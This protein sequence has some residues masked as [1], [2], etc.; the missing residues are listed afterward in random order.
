MITPLCN[1]RRCP[2]IAPNPEKVQMQLLCVKNLY[3]LSPFT[4]TPKFQLSKFWAFPTRAC[5]ELGLTID[6]ERLVLW[7]FSSLVVL[8]TGTGTWSVLKYNFRVLVLVL[9]LGPLVLVLVLVL[10]RKY[11]LPRQSHFLLYL[12][13]SGICTLRLWVSGLL[14]FMSKFH[15]LTLFGGLAIHKFFGLSDRLSLRQLGFL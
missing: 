6:W 1:Y 2:P 11:L 9:V 10:V 3:L 8:S 5:A 12:T 13:H 14:V 4:F 7:L 15:H